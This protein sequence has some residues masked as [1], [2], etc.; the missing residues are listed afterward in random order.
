MAEYVLKLGHRKIAVIS[1][2]FAIEDRVQR[3]QGIRESL[4]EWG[5][6]LA[7]SQ[8]VHAAPN[9]EGGEIAMR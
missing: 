4:A 5:I 1:S 3:E 7:D 9:Q 6:D 8:I 2:D